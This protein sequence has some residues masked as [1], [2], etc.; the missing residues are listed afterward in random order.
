M[1]AGLCNI[2]LLK[3]HHGNVV[4]L[5]L[6]FL[7]VFLT[8]FAFSFRTLPPMINI[9][10]NTAISATLDAISPDDIAI[11]IRSIGFIASAPRAGRP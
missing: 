6:L 11:S 5:L 8:H 7:Q 1:D 9:V 4:A 3:S 2:L 10:A